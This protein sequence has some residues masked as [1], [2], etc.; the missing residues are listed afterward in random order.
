MRFSDFCSLT[1][2]YES[3]TKQPNTKALQY[4]F[5]SERSQSFVFY[6]HTYKKCW[7]KSKKSRDYLLKIVKSFRNAFSKCSLT[8]KPAWW[9]A[10]AGRFICGLLVGL[11]KLNFNDRSKYFT[12]KT[13]T[14]SSFTNSF[15]MKCRPWKSYHILLWPGRELSKISENGIKCHHAS[16]SLNPFNVKR[17]CFLD[18]STWIYLFS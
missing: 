9:I 14:N 12:F 4:S 18:F 13:T 2:T 8:H 10:R 7:V 5:I 17:A 1:L 3:K 15:P 16:A 11:G 6:Q